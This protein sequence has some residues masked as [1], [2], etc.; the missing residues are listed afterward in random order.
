MSSNVESW[1]VQHC[2]CELASS[3]QACWA[4]PLAGVDGVYRD[5]LRASLATESCV[6]RS[7]PLLQGKKALSAEARHGATTSEPYTQTPAA[8][9]P[10]LDLIEVPPSDYV[11]KPPAIDKVSTTSPIGTN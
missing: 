5:R 1:P 10:L 2:I 3:L 7:D 6:T 9:V 11:T 4:V 8:D